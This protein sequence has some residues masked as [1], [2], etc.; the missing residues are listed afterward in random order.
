MRR[1]LLSIALL[2]AAA[3]AAVATAGTH[4][5]ARLVLQPAEVRDLP[6]TVQA[7]TALSTRDLAQRFDIPTALGAEVAATAAYSAA[8][9]KAGIDG[10]SALVVVFPGSTQAHEA[11]LRFVVTPGGGAAGTVEHVVPPAI[12]DEA[13]SSATTTSLPT[14]HLIELD[15]AWRY[16]RAVVYLD[17][18]GDART[19]SAEMLAVAR[20]QQRRLVAALR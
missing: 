8:G 14:F 20:A 18:Q 13:T 6:V 11:L 19:K 4:P 3:A 12:G 15:L 9:R 16:K 7:P 2:A 17:A 1:C 5:A 10:L